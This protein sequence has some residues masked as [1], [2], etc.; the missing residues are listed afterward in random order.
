MEKQKPKPLPNPTKIKEKKIQNIGPV[1]SALMS[2]KKQKIWW[3]VI[4]ATIG[5]ISGSWNVLI[6]MKIRHGFV[7][8]VRRSIKHLRN[9]SLNLMMYKTIKIQLVYSC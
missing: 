2:E 4:C 3:N 8:T 6:I 1:Q 9:S 5:I 7:R